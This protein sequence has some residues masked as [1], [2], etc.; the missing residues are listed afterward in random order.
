MSLKIAISDIQFSQ[1]TG[2]QISLVK[3]PPFKSQIE[4][5]KR[6]RFAITNFLAEVAAPLFRRN[7][8]STF[9]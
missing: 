8:F 6:H 4:F 3:N 2:K 7:P 9:V 1:L 5:S